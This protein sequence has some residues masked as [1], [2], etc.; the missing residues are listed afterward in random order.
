MACITRVSLV[1]PSTWVQSQAY[2]FAS[3]LLTVPLNFSATAN[4]LL[5]PEENTRRH[6]HGQRN[7][8]LERTTKD[9][10]DKDDTEEY[11]DTET[12]G[13]LLHGGEEGLIADRWCRVEQ[14]VGLFA[15]DGYV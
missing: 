6:T 12:G 13:S 14:N 8:A 3:D 1:A 5:G 4:H 11:T 9:V 7:E 2:G 10:S 15:V